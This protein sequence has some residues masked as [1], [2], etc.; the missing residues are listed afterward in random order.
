MDNSN[1]NYEIKSAHNKVPSQKAQLIKA[2]H[3]ILRTIE[4][5]CKTFFVN[6]DE[7]VH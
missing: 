7:N 2:P 4:K 3:I 5:K 6:K 1:K